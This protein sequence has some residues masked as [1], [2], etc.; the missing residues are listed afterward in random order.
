MFKINS[1]EGKQIFFKK[2]HEEYGKRTGN[3]IINIIPKNMQ[4]YK[5]INTFDLLYYVYKV[6]TGKSNK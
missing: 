5:I 6:W 1:G 2:S 4:T 3:V